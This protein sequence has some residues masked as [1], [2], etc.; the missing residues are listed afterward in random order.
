MLL[1]RALGAAALQS[2]F[3]LLGVRGAVGAAE[4][5]LP[6]PVFGD[7][8]ANT[9]G[10]RGLA[11]SRTIH[12]RNPAG[13]RARSHGVVALQLLP[14]HLS[15]TRQLCVTGWSG[16]PELTV[17]DRLSALGHATL[18]VSTAMALARGRLLP[19]ITILTL[20]AFVA[21]ATVGLALRCTHTMDTSVVLTGVWCC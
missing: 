20:V 9:G 4:N 12:A 1:Q 6:P 17:A 7:A 16:V 13:G 10:R 18:P 5:R 2:S 14:H 3:H 21:L 19:S 11:G 8:T 15:L